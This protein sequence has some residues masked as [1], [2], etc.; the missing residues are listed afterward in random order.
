MRQFGSM[1]A[2]VAVAAGLR[3]GVAGGVGHRSSEGLPAETE[4]MYRLYNP[5]SG[6]HFTASGGERDYLVRVGWSP[7]APA[8]RRRRPTP[9]SP[10]LQPQRGRPPLHLAGA[11][12]TT[13]S[14]GW[15]TG[16]LVLERHRGRPPLPPVQ[17]NAKAGAHNHTTSKAENDY[18]VRV[19]WNAEGLAGT[20]STETQR[21]RSRMPTIPSPRTSPSRLGPRLTQRPSSPRPPGYPT[22]QRSPGQRRPIPPVRHTVRYCHGHLSMDGPT[23]CASL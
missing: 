6:E 9:R 11:S 23:P 8:G 13:C 7:R 20:A 21:A 10:A 17:P 16:S 2:V 14:V 4:P 1:A 3:F 19:G 22:A 5:N 15:R 18:L 12:A